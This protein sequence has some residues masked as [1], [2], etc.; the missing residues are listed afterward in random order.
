M[1]KK[2]GEK[3]SRKKSLIGIAAGVLLLLAGLTV[4]RIGFSDKETTSQSPP[5]PVVRIAPVKT[6]S[7]PVQQEY[8]GRVEAIQSVELQSQVGGY[9]EKLH[10]EEGS[11]VNEGALLY[12][13]ERA[14]YQARVDQAA[15]EVK[16]AKAVRKEAVRDLGRVKELRREKVVPPEDLDT[17]QSAAESSAAEVAAAEAAL[18]EAK[19]DLAYT[20]IQAPIDGKIGQA[21]VT[22]G[23]LLTAGNQVLS[24]LVQLD[25]IRVVFSVS[26]RFFLEWSNAGSGRQIKDLE[27]QI[28]LPDDELYGEE[29]QIAFV[30]NQVDASTGTVAIWARFPNQ[31]GV[32][33]PGMF[34]KVV[35]QL[36]AQS[37]QPVVPADAILQ[38]REGPYVYVLTNQNI[39]ELRRI[40]I[41]AREKDRLVVSR[42]LQSGDRLIVQGMH[43]V[44]P[45][46]KVELAQEPKAKSSS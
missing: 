12:S 42:G 45:G 7:L 21:R 2:P 14:P 41:G 31:D 3:L 13:I 15:A 27:P 11:R 5:P 32:L 29:G 34:V 18:E 26:E 44:R 46:Q 43:K 35:L 20:Q 19:V 17:A 10:F 4:W 38:D 40:T 1:T 36:P 9:L 8:T 25:P 16:R 24:T 6:A 39:T 37:P 33:L 22:A 28:R 30:D 23:N